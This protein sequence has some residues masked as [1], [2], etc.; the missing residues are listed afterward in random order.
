LVSFLLH[1]LLIG[2]LVY[3]TITMFK[4]KVSPF[5][6]AATTILIATTITTVSLA[7]QIL[8]QG[9]APVSHQI[10]LTRFIVSLNTNEKALVKSI[11]VDIGE[12][13]NKG[14][15]LFELD[16][17]QFQAIVDQ[18][19]ADLN[20]AKAEVDRLRAAL[21]LSDATI[22]QLQAQADYAIAQR[23]ANQTLL[24]EDSAA[25]AKLNVLKSTKAAEAAEAAVVQAKQSKQQSI[26]ALASGEAKVKSAQGLL[27]NASADLD[28]TTYTAPADGV[29]INWQVRPGTISNVLRLGAVGT[30]METGNDRIIGV[31][32][33]NLLRNVKPGDAAEIAFK[34]NPGD[35]AAGKVLRIA[36]YTGEGQLVA[37]G[38]VPVL[39]NIGSKGFFAVVIQLDNPELAASLGLGEAGSATVYTKPEGLFHVLSWMYIRLISILNYLP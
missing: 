19:S 4:I 15:V 23:D 28:R 12:S 9:A 38:D 13:V 22:S 29:M 34:S 35:I 30:F 1:A 7:T 33:Q 3:L 27:D 14:D 8:W 24:R 37:S 36:N 5:S 18:Y 10:T 17:T 2:S 26:F 16:K 25:V 11:N 31:F 6:I 32:P 21:D 20:A 39:A